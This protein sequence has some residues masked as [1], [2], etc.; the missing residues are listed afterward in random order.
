MR[1]KTDD[2]HRF[3]DD[4]AGKL[5]KD[6]VWG[7][8]RVDC[9]YQFLADAVSP[10][11]RDILVVGCGPGHVGFFLAGRAR[12][13]RVVASDLSDECIRLGSRLFRHPRVQYRVLDVIADSINGAFDLMVLPDVYEH[14]PTV[15]RGVVHERLGRA[16]RANGRIA[17]TGPTPGHQAML[18]AGGGALQPVDE[19]VTLDDL[20]TF[21]GAV[22]GSLTFYRTISVWRTNDYFHALIER[23]VEPV[24]RVTDMDK[25]A[26]KGWPR[27]EA[28]CRGV[29]RWWRRL[30]LARA[31]LKVG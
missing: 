11:D 8:P 18:R 10:A 23:G 27:R 22:G 3:Y 6:Y 1:A 15:S 14:I 21:A 30:R 24:H 13:A 25:Y 5:L 9:Q 19:D 7:N 26:L 28:V 31:G 4:F 29:R 12:A 20:Q 2:L 17:I 16:L